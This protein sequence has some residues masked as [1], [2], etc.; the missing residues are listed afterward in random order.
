MKVG[1]ITTHY[2]NNYGALLQ[3]FALQYVLREQLEQETEIIGFYPPWHESSY[4]VFMRND[5]FRNLARNVVAF[6]HP[7]MLYGRYARGKRNREFAQKHLVR[8]K[9]S[10]FDTKTLRENPPRYDCYICGSDQVWNTELRW[11]EAF[12]LDFTMGMK[13]VLKFSYAPSVLSRIS[14]DKVQEVRGYLQN[15]D[16]I[17]VREREDIDQIAR[18]AERPV[19]RMPDPVFLLTPDEWRKKAVL[20]RRAGPYILCYFIGGEKQAEPLVKEIQK[21]T[22]FPTINLNTS[23]RKSI[24]NAKTVLAADPLEFIG[25]IANASIVCTNSFH[26]TAFSTI[27]SKPFL[28]AGINAKRSARMENLLKDFELPNRTLSAMEIDML[29]RENLLA[30]STDPRQLQAL[31]SMGIDFLRKGLRIPLEADNEEKAP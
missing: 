27:F 26:C 7:K 19:C 3:A 18:I 11:M 30:V 29:S 6:F 15:L 21:K 4:R 5:S 1:T 25:Y 9:Q 22:G 31:R 14:P 16:M 20:P 8:S 28:L 24:A 13:D 2:A 23:L 17:S 12:F 10:Y